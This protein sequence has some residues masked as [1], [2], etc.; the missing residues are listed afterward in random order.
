MSASAERWREPGFEGDWLVFRLVFSNAGFEIGL[1]VLEGRRSPSLF[2]IPVTWRVAGEPP[3]PPPVD[4]AERFG[5]RFE[6]LTPSER[7]ERPW[8][9]GYLRTPG[10]RAE[11]PKGWFP[12]ASLRSRN[13]YPIRFLERSGR[14]RGTVTRLEADE[15]PPASES[16]GWSPEEHAGRHGASAAWNQ[17]TGAQLLVAPEGH[18]YLFDPEDVGSAETREAWRLMLDSVQLTRGGSRRKSKK[19]SD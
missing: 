14:T 5:I 2:W 6:Q 9:E 3:A 1:P 8:M 15:V 16:E 19:K 7:G 4:P 18:A 10:L 11:V 12:A 17:A 13:G